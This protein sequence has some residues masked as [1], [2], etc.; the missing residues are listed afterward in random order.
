MRRVAFVP[1]RHPEWQAAAGHRE[2]LAAWDRRMHLP[3]VLAAILPIVLG[4]SQASE[5][6][7]IAIAV[8]VVAW[9]VFVA[10]LGVHMRLV[11]G[12]VKTGSESSI[13]RSSSSPPRGS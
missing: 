6:S 10:D 7:G 2:R 3:I 8:N 5:D 13:W 1:G 4:L 11:R 12:Y 9:I